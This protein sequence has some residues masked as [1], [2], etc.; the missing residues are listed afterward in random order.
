[1]LPALMRPVFTCDLLLRGN[2]R[3]RDYVAAE[4]E[5]RGQPMRFVAGRTGFVARVH[6]L[7]RVVTSEQPPGPFLCAERRSLIDGGCLR[8]QYRH[9]DCVPIGVEP[10][11][12]TPGD[13]RSH[14]LS[15]PWGGPEG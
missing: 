12:S 7:R 3:G 15:A 8:T 2:E 11:M 13:G 5:G 6:D 9:C 14:R 10:D 4:A 1:M